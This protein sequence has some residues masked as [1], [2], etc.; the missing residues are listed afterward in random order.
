MLFSFNCYCHQA[1]LLMRANDGYAG[2]WLWSR[3]AVTQGD[4]LAMILYGL[5]ML[6]L[7]LHLKAVVPN[8]LQPWY[9]NDAVVGGNFDEVKKVSSLL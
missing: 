8:A 4:P 3:E 2:H 6:L 5:G 1:L 7:T 9:A